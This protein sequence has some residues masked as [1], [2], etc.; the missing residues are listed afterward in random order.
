MPDVC[1]RVL[2]STVISVVSLVM[3]SATPV[4][5]QPLVENPMDV[6][7]PTEWDRVEGAVDRAL[8][9]LAANQDPDGR[10]R[11]VPIHG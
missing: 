3:L 7:S 10:F 2:A 9:F 4:F 1:L 8:R 5:A 6:L 11:T